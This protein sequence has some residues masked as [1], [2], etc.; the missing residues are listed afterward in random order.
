MAHAQGAEA[1]ASYLVGAIVAKPNVAFLAAALTPIVAP[2]LMAL[3][4]SVSPYL[5]LLGL[6]ALDFYTAVRAA[7]M[8]GQA[9]TSQIMREK[10]LP[11]LKDYTLA[12]MGG[13]LTSAATGWQGWTMGI[14]GF[15][16]IWELWSILAE[17]LNDGGNVPFDFRQMP[18]LKQIAA[19]ITGTRRG[20]TAAEQAQVPTD[21]GGIIA[22]LTGPIL[23]PPITPIPAPTP[24]PGTTPA[25][26]PAPALATS[27][28]LSDAAAVKA[29]HETE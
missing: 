12:V 14:V 2:L 15:L 25:P 17:N 6:V 13:A 24:A 11:K 4:A 22:G 9:V 16:A 18:I 26:T 5:A 29:A 3:Q 8:K 20:A 1:S 28:A 27:P 7:R 19:L 10:G 23:A 21:L